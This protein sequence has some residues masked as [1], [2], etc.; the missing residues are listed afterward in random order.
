[1]VSVGIEVVVISF[2]IVVLKGGVVNLTCSVS[3]EAA[4][5]E[6]A[7]VGFSLVVV[8]LFV[9]GLME[10]VVMVVVIFG[11]V[12]IDVVCS[13]GVQVNNIM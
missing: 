11:I 10:G 5:D 7:G 3:V 6:A 13:F 4:A 12:K 1:M 2:L 9:E 8:V